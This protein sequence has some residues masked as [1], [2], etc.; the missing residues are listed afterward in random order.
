MII[1]AF[2]LGL[3]P[4]W[5]TW[6][7]A[8]WI[9]VP[10]TETPRIAAIVYVI[11][12]TCAFSVI[13]QTRE[14]KQKVDRVQ[15]HKNRYVCSHDLCPL[16]LGIK[17]P[18]DSF[19]LLHI[20][21]GSESWESCWCA[22]HAIQ[23]INNACRER[24]HKSIP[25]TTHVMPQS[26]MKLMYNRRKQGHA[27][28]QTCSNKLPIHQIKFN[29]SLCNLAGFSNDDLREQEKGQVQFKF[30]AKGSSFIPDTKG[31]VCTLPQQ[32]SVSVNDRWVVIYFHRSALLNESHFIIQLSIM[33]RILK[34]CVLWEEETYV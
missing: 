21:A 25:F 11:S 30:K 23:H 33:P 7:C 31:H 19:C 9:F 20:L 27:H 32:W 4:S 28:P 17:R 3:T 6:H 2:H 10:L 34:C 29:K 22:S 5:E 26:E 1:A 14:V 16:P 13:C 18:F 12:Y 15:Q 24:F 8:C